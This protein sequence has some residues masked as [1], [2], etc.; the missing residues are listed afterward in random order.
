MMKF[1]DIETYFG[2]IASN[3]ARGDHND[4]NWSAISIVYGDYNEMDYS[5]TG[6]LT[7]HNFYHAKGNICS[8]KFR[9]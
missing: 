3:L 2:T 1:P 9:Y 6:P 7:G 4:I 8:M 5:H